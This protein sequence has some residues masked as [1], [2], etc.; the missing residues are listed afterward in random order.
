MY[1]IMQSKKGRFNTY[2]I[3]NDELKVSMEVIPERGGIVS[4][5]TVNDENILYMEEDTLLNESTSVHGGIPVLFPIC[6]LL[7]DN[8]YTSLGKEYSLK[9]HGFARNYPWQVY[10]KEL[11]EKSGSITLRFV[12]SEETLAVYPYKFE[13]FVKY[14]LNAEGLKVKTK[15]CNKSGECMP[16]YMGFHPYFNV[17]R[18]SNVEFDIPYSSIIDEFDNGFKNGNINIINDETNITFCHPQRHRAL[19]RDTGNN[20]EIEIKYDDSV[21]YLVL[22]AQGKNEFV[23]IEPW[24]AN[25]DAMNSGKDLTKLKPGEWF[26][27]DFDIVIR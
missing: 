22:W 2:I 16:F 26:N 20:T 17:T 8:K 14:I 13:L 25:V 12:S 5:L 9:R 19:M 15:V 3:K 6:G 23:C 11:C 1:T 27:M 10:E 18:K 4:G 24:M 21:K 7:K